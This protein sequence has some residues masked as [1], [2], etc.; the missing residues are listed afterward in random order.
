MPHRA[1]TDTGQLHACNLSL[2]GNR[3]A[4]RQ[5][6]LLPD[7]PIAGCLRSTW[8]AVTMIARFVIAAHSAGSHLLRLCSGQ[9]LSS[10]TIYHQQRI[11]DTTSP[12]PLLRLRLVRGPPAK[13]MTQLPLQTTDD[14]PPD[15][16]SLNSSQHREPRRGQ[17]ETASEQPASGASDSTQD[18]GPDKAKIEANMQLFEKYITMAEVEASGDRLYDKYG[19]KPKE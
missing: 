19:R 11:Y 8:G 16:D 15:I 17:N 9:L 6:F 10:S 12:A 2:R 5:A 4:C 14:A 13:M 1:E 18:K 7:F 3:D